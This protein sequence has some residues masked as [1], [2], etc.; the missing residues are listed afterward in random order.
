MPTPSEAA[1][2]E[3]WELFRRT[4]P[5]GAFLEIR[6]PNGAA[7]LASGPITE[8]QANKAAAAPDLYEACRQALAAFTHGWAIDADGLRRALQ[9]AK[10]ANPTAFGPM[11]GSAKLPTE[12]WDSK[13]GRSNSS[14]QFE[15]ISRFI[16]SLIRQSAASLIC[17]GTETV[18]RLILAQLAHGRYNM[19]PAASKPVNPT[20]DVTPSAAVAHHIAHFASFPPEPVNRVA[21][22]LANIPPTKTTPLEQYGFDV[23]SRLAAIMGHTLETNKPIDAE[24]LLEEVR[25][26]KHPFEIHNAPRPDDWQCPICN[27]R[28]A[29]IW[30][31]CWHCFRPRGDVAN[32]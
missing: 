28:N 17:G 15:E 27:A 12:T 7:L 18:G 2:E 21:Q 9:K 5:P 19:A 10:K 11:E 6:M 24:Q 3:R 30:S 22:A 31:K 13:D 26:L 20:K 1:T 32:V 29:S 8:E 25:Q 4:S 14:A 23:I 16:A